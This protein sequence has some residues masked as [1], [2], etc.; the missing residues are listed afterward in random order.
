MPVRKQVPLNVVPLNSC[1][2]ANALK[3]CTS[4]NGCEKANAHK[5]CTSVNGC[6]KASAHK[7]CT[8][9]NGCEKASAH[10]PCTSVNGCE[11]ASALTLYGGCGAPGYRDEEAL[12]MRLRSDR[13]TTTKAIA[14]RKASPRK[15]TA[16]PRPA[17]ATREW[18]MVNFRP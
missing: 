10:K 6:E 9:V 12:P 5:P 8:S 13:R 14:R 16:T 15:R 4:V 18:A 2:K 3:P 7:P 1:E 11:K 17:D